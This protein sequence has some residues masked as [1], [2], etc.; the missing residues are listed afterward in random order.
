MQT[1]KEKKGNTIAGQSNELK[2]L[3]IDDYDWVS[4]YYNVNQNG[5]W[6]KAKIFYLKQRAMVTLLK[7]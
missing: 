6:E 3:L 4:D 5:F 1:V 2:E 7:K